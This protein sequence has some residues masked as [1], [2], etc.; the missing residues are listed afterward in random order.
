MTVFQTGNSLQGY[1]NYGRTWNGY[2]TGATGPV[3]IDE[4][5]QEQNTTG[6]GQVNMETSDGGTEVITAWAGIY[7]DLTGSYKAFGG[8]HYTGGAG[9]GILMI[10]PGVSAAS[11][12]TE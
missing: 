6:G 9:G 7:T 11:S 12:D 1:D 4:N 5:L 2:I 8:Q 10:G 3:V